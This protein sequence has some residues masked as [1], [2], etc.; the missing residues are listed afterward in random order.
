MVRAIAFE[1]EIFTDRLRTL[2]DN[3]ELYI[4]RRSISRT[5]GD[6]PQTVRS[7]RRVPRMY[8]GCTKVFTK[9]WS[10]ARTTGHPLERLCSLVFLN[11]R[12]EGRPPA[13]P[14]TRPGGYEIRREKRQSPAERLHEP[15][16]YTSSQLPPSSNP[17]MTAA[18]YA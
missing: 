13:W 9:V 2:H 12:Y 8:Q 1:P 7:L 16:C 3:L 14:L 10:V 4:G 17:A 6:I 15:P 11:L 18:N 5:R